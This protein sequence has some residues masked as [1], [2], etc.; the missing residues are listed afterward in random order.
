[1]KL[2]KSQ[3][4]MLRFAQDPQAKARGGWYVALIVYVV[5]FV[6][7]EFLRPKP[8]L[9]DAVPAGLG[10]FGFPTATEDRVVPLIWGT[11]QQAGPNV[12]W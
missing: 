11:V 9:E 10:D 5:V 2:T 1:M 6:V 3:K 4:A 7:S 12:V 8:K